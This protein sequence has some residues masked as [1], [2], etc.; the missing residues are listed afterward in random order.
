MEEQEA[1][2][3]KFQDQKMTLGVLNYLIELTS[4]LPAPK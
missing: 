3:E 2:V 1:F 4:K